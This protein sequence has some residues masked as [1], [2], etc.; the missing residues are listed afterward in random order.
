MMPIKKIVVAF[1]VA[2]T[3]ALVCHRA[4]AQTP[5]DWAPLAGIPSLVLKT[6]SLSSVR[7]VAVA[8]ELTD[9]QTQIVA[10][11]VTAGSYFVSVSEI[12]NGWYAHLAPN[13]NRNVAFPV[14][15]FSPILQSAQ[16]LNASANVL[17][18]A[19]DSYQNAV[20]KVRAKIRKCFESDPTEQNVL[21]ELDHFD[22]TLNDNQSAIDAFTGQ[23]QSNLSDDA[24][25]WQ[26]FE[27]HLIQIL[28]GTFLPL[29]QDAGSYVQ[30][31]NFIKQNGEIISKK[32]DPIIKALADL[33]AK[34]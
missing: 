20:S 34:P 18:S 17:D 33:H 10:D 28:N 22:Q 8:T 13:E 31:A 23:L 25:D 3:V 21:S 16:N 12:Y 11:A 32:L 1:L 4:V 6:A 2:A 30:G 7:C 24:S 9:L 26:Q 27:G 19:A 14:G 5:R 15:Y 29:Q